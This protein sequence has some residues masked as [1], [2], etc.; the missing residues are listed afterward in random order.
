M[1][2]FLV[3]VASQGGIYRS[4]DFGD[5]WSL[6]TSPA[7]TTLNWKS[8]ASSEDGKVSRVGP[9]QA[10]KQA[11]FVGLVSDRYLAP[12]SELWA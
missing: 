4:A 1:W 8:I 12:A 2:Q 11:C 3:A 10:S 9:P 5:S 7:L 6:V